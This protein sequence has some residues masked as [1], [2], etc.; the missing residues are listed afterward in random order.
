MCNEQATYTYDGEA[1]HSTIGR[2]TIGNNYLCI[3][4]DSLLDTQILLIDDEG[5]M[6]WEDC[7]NFTCSLTPIFVSLILEIE[8]DT[9]TK[10]DYI[11]HAV[12]YDEWS[13]EKIS[14][15]VLKH[16]FK[17]TTHQ[18]HV[19]KLVRGRLDEL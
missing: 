8:I 4:D 13:D 11:I 12:G 10:R 18:I 9:K 19:V 17:R 16:Q 6:C 15:H 1:I 3:K 7:R 2:Y 14:N 5:N